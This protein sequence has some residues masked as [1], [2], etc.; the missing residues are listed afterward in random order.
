MDAFGKIAIYVLTTTLFFSAWVGAELPC[1]SQG[2]Q[3]PH[4]VAAN[5]GSTTNHDA[6][7]IEHA[8]HA[9]AD[10]SDQDVIPSS[11]DCPCCDDCAMVCAGV[12]G[13][14]MASVSVSSEPPYDLRSRLMSSIVIF[15]PQPP[16]QSLFRPPIS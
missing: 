12:G 3:P 14:A 1:Q 16:S 10:H 15:R 11:D 8:H 7:T 2:A 13:N 6:S 9:A 5:Y 4:T